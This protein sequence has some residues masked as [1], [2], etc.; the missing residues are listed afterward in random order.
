MADGGRLWCGL[1]SSPPSASISVQFRNVFLRSS[2][3]SE[4]LVGGQ[5]VMEQ[6]GNNNNNNKKKRENE[7]N[8]KEGSKKPRRKRL[9]G[10][11]SW[12]GNWAA[13]NR[14]ASRARLGRKS[15][16]YYNLFPTNQ[17]KEENTQMCVPFF[18]SSF[19]S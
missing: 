1:D 18:S 4:T 17:K 16:R 9:K 6:E 2:G 7:R 11:D 12:G 19:F 3:H 15:L 13:I 8:E 10:T 5:I 14:S